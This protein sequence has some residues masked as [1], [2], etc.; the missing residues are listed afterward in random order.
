MRAY[1]QFPQPDLHRLDTRPY[2]LQTEPLIIDPALVYSTYLGGSYEDTGYGIAVDSSGNAYITGYTWSDD[3]P[4][5]L[6]STYGGSGDVFVTKLNATGSALIY[7]T[8]LGGRSN[9]YGHGI[10]VDADGNAYITGDTSSD[11]FPTV[12]PLQPDYGEWGDAFVVKLNASGS[13]LIYSTYLGGSYHDNANGIAV[14]RWGSAYIT[15]ET[16]SADFP[17]QDALQP[18]HGGGYDAFVAKLN[19]AGSQLVYSTYL[20]G[21]SGDNGGG[22]A[23]DALENA[24]VTGVAGSNDFPRTPGAY[25]TAFG[26]GEDAFV[27]K[28][29]AA[30]STLV[31]STYLGGTSYDGGN[32]VSVDVDGNAYITGFASEG[33]PTA[34]A[35]QPDYG[36]GPHDAFVA[37]LNATGSALIYSTYLG[38]SGLDWG[39]GIAIDTSGNAY[40]TGQTNS[41]GFP[42]QDPFQPDPGG[43]VDAFVV[44]LNAS[45]SGLVYSTYLGGGS[46]DYGTGIA[47]DADGNAY[48][49]GGTASSNFPTVGPLQPSNAGEFDA[50]VAKIGTAQQVTIDGAVNH[51]IIDGF[52]GSVAFYESWLPSMIEPARTDVVNLLFRDLGGGILRLRTWTGI[53]PENDDED[54]DHFN[55]DGFDFSSD[56]NQ[57]WI[58]AA[59]ERRGVSKI[60]SSVWSPPGWMKDTGTE[61]GGGSLLP[62]M[63]PEFAEWLTAYIKGYLAYHNIDIGWVSLQNEPNWSASWP[64]CTYTTEQLRDLT[65]VVGAKFAAEGI[66]TNIVIPETTGV[67]NASDYINA[68]MSDPVAAG[69]VDILAH[70]LYDV[71]FYSP[72]SRI[73]DMDNLGVLASAYGRP[74][75]QTEYSDTGSSYAGTFDEALR[76]AIHIYNTLVY[77][78]AAAYLVWGLF[79]DDSS[80]G[81]GLILIPDQGASVY[82]VT[83]KYYACKQFFKYIPIGAVRK[84]VTSSDGDILV[85]AYQSADTLVIVAINRSSYSK[86]VTFNLQ[87][88][89]LEDIV[90]HQFRTSLTEN[91]TYIGETPASNDTFDVALPKRSITTFTTNLLPV[92]DAGEDQHVAVNS[93]VQLDGSGSIDPD[94]DSLAYSWTLVRKPTG[95]DTMLVASNTPLPTFT[96]DTSG[97]YIAKLIVDDRHGGTASSKVIISAIG[98]SAVFKVNVAG[99][100]LADGPFYGAAFNSGSADV[101]E[102]VPVSEPVAPGDVLELDPTSPGQYRKARGPCSTLVAGVVSSDPGVILGSEPQTHNSGLAT[103]DSAL[104]A[105]IGFVPVKVCDENGPIQPGDLLTTSSVPGYAMRCNDPKKCQGAIIGKALES[106]EEKIGVIKMLVMK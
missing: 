66:N 101:A 85:S 45:G 100:V 70:H 59:A 43:N 2:G 30:G 51:Q 17:T 95:S 64:T 103:E 97:N 82:T 10:T 31:Y 62:S 98:S 26:G 15:G 88:M 3:F 89:D 11:N 38:G 90:F 57:T 105:L 19:A 83:P 24:Y 22:I 40:V 48:V 54:P 72:D 77:E 28:I 74:L 6:Q 47:V 18:D 29:N 25:Q 13:A 92:A 106:L 87:N 5:P 61:P 14:D 65:K 53:E 93:I 73:S 8:Y 84:E 81:E 49:T 68:T 16:L 36:G 96:P 9:D 41:G 37:K 69:Y 33:F 23:V 58:A 7:S 94:G 42:T 1:S 56:F 39:N 79:W 71:P 20:G 52:G 55:W 99:N 4:N 27:T 102:W 104:L 21:S 76:T 60:I 75:W 32:D 63:Y 80:P 86:N 78:N 91:A 34:N 35:L 46:N 44:K 50:F 67:T 12:N